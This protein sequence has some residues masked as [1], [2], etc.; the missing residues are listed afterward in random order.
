MDTWGGPIERSFDG[1]PEVVAGAREHV[2]LI[3]QGN[4]NSATETSFFSMCLE[5]IQKSSKQED[6]SPSEC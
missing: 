2:P 3:F 4:P 1:C 5:E 6:P